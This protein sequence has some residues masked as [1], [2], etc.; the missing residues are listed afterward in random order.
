M[1]LADERR[2]FFYRLRFLFALPHDDDLTMLHLS[3][4]PRSCY[5]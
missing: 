4:E 1:T 3:L 2:K 5:K